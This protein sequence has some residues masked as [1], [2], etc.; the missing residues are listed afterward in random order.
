MRLVI[1]PLKEPVLSHLT[2]KND[3]ILTPE[4]AQVEHGIEAALYEWLAR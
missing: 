2:T 3:R 1:W 4:L